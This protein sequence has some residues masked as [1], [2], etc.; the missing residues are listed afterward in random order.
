M[1][2][3][4]FSPLREAAEESKTARVYREMRRRIRELELP[5]GAPL[6]KEEIALELGVSRA[7]VSEAIAR[8]A[9]EALVDVYPQHGSFVAP[10]RAADVRESLFIRTA[11]EVE[12]IRRV[13]EVADAALLEKLDANL[14]EEAG[15]LHTG[16]LAYFQDLDEALHATIFSAI[17][18]PRALRLLDAARAPLDRPRRLALPEEGRARATYLEHV[19]LVESIRSGDA[20]FAGAAMRVHLSMVTRSIEAALAQIDEKKV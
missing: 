12:A 11:L 18:C 3:V 1:E 20:E 13:T 9:D 5:P 10:I 15:A 8:L 16:D 14:K 17:E 6:R 2:T 19:R 7:P 4:G